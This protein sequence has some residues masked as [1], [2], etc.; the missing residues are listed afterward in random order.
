[1]LISHFW[2]RLIHQECL[3]LLPGIKSDM[4]TFL[5]RGIIK[6]MIYFMRRSFY[7]LNYRCLCGII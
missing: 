6:Y 7:T 1:M 4:I 3:C 5:V 2:I